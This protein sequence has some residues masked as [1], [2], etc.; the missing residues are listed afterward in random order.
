M[1]S[2]QR[3]TPG[4]SGYADISYRPAAPECC[5]VFPIQDTVKSRIECTVDVW[6]LGAVFSEALLWTI[7]GE[8]GRE[9]YR[10][11]RAAAI[12]QTPLAKSG[13]DAAFHNGAD[14]LEVVDATHFSALQN[15][16]V[17]DTVSP[18][19]SQV[20]LEYMLRRQGKG[21]LRAN[22]TA[23]QATNKLNE[24]RNLKSEPHVESPPTP[25]STISR[26]TWSRSEATGSARPPLSHDLNQ[27]AT[28][29]TMSTR[30][31]DTNANGNTHKCRSEPPAS[32]P[33]TVEPVPPETTGLGATRRT[34]VYAE[35]SVTR[36]MPPFYAPPSRIVNASTEHFVSVRSVYDELTRKDRIFL[37][38]LRGAGANVL[39]LPGIQ[40]ARALIQSQ[41]GR[42]QASVLPVQY[43]NAY[44]HLVF[45]LGW[46]TTP[47]HRLSSLMISAQ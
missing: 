34:S 32:P 45:S 33:A 47:P 39:T 7:Y 44:T 12:L 13:Y 19:M 26:G 4:R 28:D 46:L 23:V 18:K 5:P 42:K 22:D 36:E 17:S 10:L 27:R 35:P 20:I 40:E 38:R 41:S 29:P 9:T 16:R 8:R 14:R 11:A 43:S 2:E 25:P 15:K 31:N 6:A 3:L 37:H 30:H 1:P 24:A 21:R